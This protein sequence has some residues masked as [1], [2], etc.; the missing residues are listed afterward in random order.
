MLPDTVTQKLDSLPA[1]PGCYLFRDRKSRVLYVGKAKSLRARVRSYFQSG[2]SDTR[3]FIPHLLRLVGDLETVVTATEKEAAILENNLIKE[4]RPRF[5]VKLRDDK[6]YLTLRLSLSHE[7]PRLELV[8]RPTADGARYFG[9]YHSA[10]AARR[11]LHLVEKHF[12]LRTCSDRELVSRKRPCLQYQIRRC[13]AP[14]VFDI[15]PEE[16]A[17]QVRAVALFLEGRHDELSRELEQRMATA[18]ERFEYELAARYRDQ[19][20]AVASL[21]EQQRVVA[22]S[23][24]DQDVLGLYREGE[25]VELSVLYVR[26]GRVVDT[27]SFSAG[28]AE[29][30]DDEVVAAFLRQH[31]GEGGAGAGFVPDEV[32]VPLLPEVSD[33]VAEWLSDR[34]AQLGSAPGNRRRCRLLAPRRGPLA[35]LRTLAEDNARHAFEEKRR[36]AEDLD[37]RLARVQERLRLPA[38]PRRMECCDISHLGGQDVVGAVVALTDGSPDK[39]RYR[40]YRVTTAQGGDDYAAMYEVLARRFRRGQKARE[41]EGQSEW[42]LPEVFVV[43]GGRG[44]LGVALTAAADLGLHDLCLIGLAKERETPLGEKLVDRVYLPGQKNPIPLRPNSPELF[45]LAKLRDEAHR[46]AN[47]GRKRLSRRRT[48]GSELDQIPGVGK[49]TRT[50]LLSELGSVARIRRATDEELLSVPG[51]TRRQVRALRDYF[52][53]A[54]GAEAPSSDSPAESSA[55][56]DSKR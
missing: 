29:A 27:G 1:R 33:G 15:N 20:R 11:T 45:L 34:R 42:E 52:G 24:K 43:D 5:N 35:K 51:L 50:V 47:R 21:R 26:A 39:Q 12:Q 17:A 2:T 8:R 36:A 23:D 18:A 28:K 53:P 41:G 31:Y 38:L 25:L 7:W 46:F 16:Y 6:E 40:T 49:K 19:L 56:E 37:E 44:Q 30:G 10:T 13:P 55:P 48:L 54:D 14:C 3:A 32:I 9:P 22:V 4:N